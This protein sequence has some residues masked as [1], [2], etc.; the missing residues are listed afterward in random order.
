MNIVFALMNC[1]N[2]SKIAIL[3]FSQ[4]ASKEASSKKWINNNHQKNFQLAR[5]LISRTEKA[6]EN[7][8]FPVFRFRET[9]QIGKNFGE[10][11][12]NAYLKLFEKGFQSV[13]AIG[14]DS[15][16]IHQVDWQKIAT[17][18]Q[19]GKSIL[20]PSIR[21]GAYLIGLNRTQFD[22]KVFQQLSWQSSKLYDQLKT[23]AQKNSSVFE[24]PSL[25]DLN[26]FADLKLILQ[27]S[28][29]CGDFKQ[30][31]INLLQTEFTYFEFNS[32]LVLKT[33]FR[34]HFQRGPPLA[35]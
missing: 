13:I 7:A 4:S 22:A 19:N 21:G 26:T 27:N 18:L 3:F 31:L 20:G 34:L 8:P 10:R 32:H 24:L 16:E 1:M 30:L 9:E 12:T 23:L 11:L 25:R 2:S 15:P 35:A 14:N 6:L 29:L 28:T 17:Q 5:S 33:H